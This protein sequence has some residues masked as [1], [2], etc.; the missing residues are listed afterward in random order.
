MSEEGGQPYQGQPL[1]DN[2][3]T[4]RTIRQQGEIDMRKFSN[5]ENGDILFLLYAGIRAKKSTTWATIKDDYLAYK[6]SVGHLG[7]TNLIR[8]ESV[9]KGGAPGPEPQPQRPNFL[10]RYTYDREGEKEFQ[11]WKKGMDQNDQ[12]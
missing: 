12:G 10:A 6:L 1:T 3:G 5:L 2:L 8:G 7:I 4:A 9:R 11:E